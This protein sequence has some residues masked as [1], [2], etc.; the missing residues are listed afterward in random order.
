MIAA[1]STRPDSPLMPLARSEPKPTDRRELEIG[2]AIQQQLFGS[3]PTALTGYEL[4]CYNEPAHDVDGDFY[5]FTQFGPASFEVLA[6]DVMGKGISAALIAVSINNTY[7]KI[8]AEMLAAHPAAVPSP[9]TL[10]NAIHAAVTPQLIDAAIFVT[11]ALLRCDQEAQTVTWVNAGH[12][13]TLLLPADGSEVHDL[14]GDNLPLGVLANESY[15]QHVAPFGPGDTLLLYSDGVSEALDA[16]RFEYGV[17]RIKAL[18]A[19]GGRTA[20]AQILDRLRQ[21]LHEYAGSAKGADDR[22]A[23]VIRAQAKANADS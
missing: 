6:G 15:V 21:D 10:I 22:S 17:D 14:L 23:I 12:T 2:A 13:P 9:A 19:H 11:L 18:L 3:P 16:R 5:T 7:R 1:E 20:P 4:A 8:L